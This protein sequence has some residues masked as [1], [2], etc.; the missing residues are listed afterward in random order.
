MLRITLIMLVQLLETETLTVDLTFGGRQSQD[1]SDQYPKA[2]LV[3]SE[4]A[5]LKLAVALMNEDV[6]IQRAG[7]SPAT[8]Q[9]IPGVV[10]AAGKTRAQ[11]IQEVELLVQHLPNVIVTRAD[12]GMFGEVRNV[13]TEAEWHETARVIRIWRSRREFGLH[14]VAVIATRKTD[15]PVAEEAALTAETFGSRVERIWDADNDDTRRRL[16]ELDSQGLQAII[17]VADSK[18]TLPLQVRQIVGVPVVSVPTSSD[19]DVVAADPVPR[20][21]ENVT[22]VEFNDGAGGALIAS[23]IIEGLVRKG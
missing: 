22:V 23:Q 5:M 11:V 13:C 3:E 21:T 4:T 14:E 20:N 8:S 10:S 2:K 12:A 15:I 1:G 6:D 9:D 7:G 18:S 19:Y 17:V 16:A